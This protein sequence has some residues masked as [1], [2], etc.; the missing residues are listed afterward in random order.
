MTMS[1]DTGETDWEQVGFVLASDYRTR[2]LH[3]L[4]DGPAMPTELGER[5]SLD[6]THVSRT[7]TELRDH[8]IAE[9]LVPEERTKGRIYGLTEAGEEVAV[10]VDV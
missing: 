1:T 9:L 5:A 4:T 3:A 8:D 10:E 2:V 7:L 6:L